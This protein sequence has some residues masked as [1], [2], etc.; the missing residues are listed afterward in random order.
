[1][2]NDSANGETLSSIPVEA[3][4]VAIDEGDRLQL[5]QDGKVYPDTMQNDNA[6]VIRSTSS[7]TYYNNISPWKEKISDD[8]FVQGNNS[9][10]VGQLWMMKYNSS[11]KLF[12]KVSYVSLGTTYNF[13][14]YSY[15]RKLKDGV[16]AVLFSQ[17]TST[18]RLAL[19]PYNTTTFALGAPVFASSISTNS[20]SI[21]SS[22]IVL[23]ETRIMFTNQNGS[24]K[25]NVFELSADNTSFVSQ[26]IN[27]AADPDVPSY[28]N[29]IDTRMGTNYGAYLGYSS[30]KYV[31]I[32]PVAATGTAINVS[33]AEDVRIPMKMLN[34]YGSQHHIVPYDKETNE[35]IFFSN[36][37]DEDQKQYYGDLIV[38]TFDEDGIQT[39]RAFKMERGSVSLG[40]FYQDK[41][42]KSNANTWYMYRTNT[43]SNG[44]Y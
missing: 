3:G 33:D 44:Y 18:H 23:D 5:K 16:I 9:S 6:E 39:T 26:S 22:I 30:S 24:I 21:T 19:I 28:G 14:E 41:Y 32:A 42:V 29:V 43:D 1:M 7:N 40:F 10:G 36:K 25:T 38:L 37:T 31:R 13:Y 34:E 35:V 17:S 20:Y 27:I 11:S 2:K 12:D 4:T 15:Y 8:V